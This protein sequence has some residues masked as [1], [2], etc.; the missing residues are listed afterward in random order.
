MS[1]TQALRASEL[2]GKEVWLDRELVG[3]VVAVGFAEGGLVRKVGVAGD[4]ENDPLRFLPIDGGKLDAAGLHLPK[5][6]DMR[7]IA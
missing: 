1:G 3:V 2:W 4:S 7:V 5:P 6:A